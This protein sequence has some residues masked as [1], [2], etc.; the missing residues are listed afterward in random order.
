VF[1]SL[2]I[3]IVWEQKEW[4]GID[5]YLCYMINNW[6][7]QH[8]SFVI[9][10]NKENKGAL[11]LKKILNNKVEVS[12]KEIRSSFRFKECV[13]FMDVLLKLTA[14]IITPLL[15]IH[16]IIKYKNIF[17]HENFDVVM[18]QNGGYPGS[19]GVI[20][21][22]F[23]ASSTGIPVR[24]LVVHHAATK[25]DFLQNSFRLIM[26]KKLSVILSSVISV[27]KVTEE[28][29]LKNTRIFDDQNCYVTVIDN[30]IP[31]DS[32]HNN[33]NESNAHLLTPTINVNDKLK[34]GILG[35]LEP[36]K[37]HD[38]FLC[39]LSLLSDKCRN[40]ISVDIIGS[41]NKCDYDRLMSIIKILDLK[42]FVNIKGYVDLPVRDIVN[43]LDLLAMVTKTFEGFG[44]TI[45]EALYQN[46]PVLAT[47]V[48]VVP[49]IFSNDSSLL[50]NVGDYN[51]IAR[52]IELFV[53]SPN[54]EIFIS[55]EVKQKLARYDAKYMASR[56]HQYF[57]FERIKIS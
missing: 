11:R 6:P 21:S 3:A 33:N 54:K 41:Y 15:F 39:A 46:V 30:G 55:E 1:D 49:E 22:L 42:D 17:K 45:I 56:Y 35:R 4:G 37:G 50:V 25:P 8:D 40:K 53:N 57:M 20:S 14:Y 47:K 26:E 7:N 52:A 48:G 2:N 28:T 44:L 51:D 34:I 24:T 16:S 38:D 29:L 9:Y 13:N 18:A 27:S 5:S 12:F 43:Q 10:Y 31:S 23:A 36:Y 19:Y 32:E